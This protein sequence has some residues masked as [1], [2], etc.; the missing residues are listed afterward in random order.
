MQQKDVDENRLILLWEVIKDNIAYYVEDSLEA[1]LRLSDPSIFMMLGMSDA[2]MLNDVIF[3]DY[4][5]DDST[6]FS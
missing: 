5:T 4:L 2:R 6:A 1:V 3:L